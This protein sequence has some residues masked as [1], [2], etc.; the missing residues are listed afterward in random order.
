MKFKNWQIIDSWG[1]EFGLPL[2]LIGLLFWIATGW[3]TEVVLGEAPQ[4]ERVSV[5]GGRLPEVE[6]LLKVQLI[7]IEAKIYEK[8]GYTKVD[9]DTD[10]STLKELEFEFPVTDVADVEAE[11]S[12]MLNLSPAQLR[13]LVRYQIYD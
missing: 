9:I 2:P 6:L 11:M 5:E 3:T 10:S 4:I 8:R 12:R 13:T 1:L 7:S